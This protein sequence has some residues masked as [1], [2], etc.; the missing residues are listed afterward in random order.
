MEH[1]HVARLEVGGF[2]NN[3]WQPQLA[4]LATQDGAV[5]MLVP[6]ASAQSMFPERYDRDYWRGITQFYG[7]MYQCYVVFVNRVGEEGQLRD[8]GQ[9]TSSTVGEVIAEAKEFEEQVLAQ[10]IKS[11]R[12]I[13]GSR[14]L[15]NFGRMKGHRTDLNPL[16]TKG[17]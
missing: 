13:K 7:R 2:R 12:I 10:D 11:S 16:Q 14:R 4:F 15:S 1:E 3:G 5:I 9:L 8:L 6:A 17:G